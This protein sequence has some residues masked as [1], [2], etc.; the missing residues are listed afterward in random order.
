MYLTNEGRRTQYP[1]VNLNFVISIILWLC[2]S[3][4]SFGVPINIVSFIVYIS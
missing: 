4:S 1:N 3:M 2:G